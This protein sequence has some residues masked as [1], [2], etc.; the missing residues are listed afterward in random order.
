M[1]MQ[2]VSL[3]V[4]REIVPL[5][6]IAPLWKGSMCLWLLLGKL[7]LIARAPLWKGNCAFAC[8]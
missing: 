5:I 8:C 7:Q 2:H 4:V 6:A 3:L 1:E